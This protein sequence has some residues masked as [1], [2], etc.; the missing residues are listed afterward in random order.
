MGNDS[1]TCNPLPN[2]YLLF[3]MRNSI[4]QISLDTD[5]LWDVQLQVPHVYNAVAVDYLWAEQRLFYTDVQI[6]VIRSV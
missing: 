4:A 5:V 2:S 1:A 3:A 6:D